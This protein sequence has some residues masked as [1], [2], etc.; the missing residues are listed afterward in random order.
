ML[1]VAQIDQ[2]FDKK[3]KI[4][5]IASLLH[6]PGS[7]IES[8]KRTWDFTLIFSTNDALDILLFDHTYE[9]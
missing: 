8:R 2:C 9:L 6:C 4:M 7:V 1:Y 5:T 3:R